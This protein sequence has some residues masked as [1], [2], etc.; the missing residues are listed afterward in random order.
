MTTLT[1]SNM[2]RR[3]FLAG[4][5]AG[6]ALALV[7]TPSFALTN[8][9]AKALVDNLVAEINSVIARGGSPATMTRAFEKIFARYGDV[10]IIAR[11]TLGPDARRATPAQMS[12]FV[13]AFAGYIARKYGKRFQE[14][15]GGRIEVNSVHP[16]KTWHEVRSTAYLRG[17]APFGLKFLI[18]D[19]SGRDLFFDMVI[20]GISLR[21]SE[22]TEIGAM[23]DRNRGDIDGLVRDLRAAG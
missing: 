14:F 12:A 8:A 10:N 23:L 1:F 3:R 20:E 5:A 6:L 11:S 19:R 9:K 4:A 22:K 13:E 16:I 21:L 17:E 18:S 7:P 2:T 15:I